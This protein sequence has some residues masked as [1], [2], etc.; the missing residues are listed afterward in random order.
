MSNVMTSVLVPAEL[1]A[2]AKEARINISELCRE[3]LK[4]ALAVNNIE[5]VRQIRDKLKEAVQEAENILDT[6]NTKIE[7]H[8]AAEKHEIENIQ[9]ICSEIPELQNLTAA[10]LQDAKFMLDLVDVVRKK[11]NIT[12]IG[13]A[14]IKKYYE[15][16][17]SK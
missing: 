6:L 7:E 13:V 15:A 3:A 10:Q 11:Y 12:N 14:Q 4:K 17:N 8:E 5:E 2:A 1:L 9:K 16:I